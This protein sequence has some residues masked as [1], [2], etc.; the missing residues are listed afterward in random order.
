M[1]NNYISSI[2]NF[3]DYDTTYLN[4]TFFRWY[5]KLVPQL[6][7]RLLTLYSKEGDKILANFSGSGTVPLECLI[8]NR[9]CI[10][11]DSNPLS[12]LLSKV[13]TNPFNFDYNRFIDYLNKCNFVKNYIAIKDIE[14]K[15]FYKESLS[16]IYFL[17]QVIEEYNCSSSEKEYLLLVLVSII[18][19]SSLV[20]SRCVNHIV[21]D[22]NKKKID[23]I[24]EYKLKLKETSVEMD[25]LLK[26]INHTNSIRIMRGDARNLDFITNNDIDLI[27]A[28]PPYLGNVD[29]TNINQ[30]ENFILDYDNSKI[31]EQDISTN[32]LR[33]YLKNMYKV[34]DE[35]NRI[36]K[37]GSRACVII[38][39]NRQEGEIIPTF[40][41]FIQYALSI[42]F[43]LEDIFIW[44]LNKKAG[45]S[46]KRHGNY[47]DHNYILVFKKQE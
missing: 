6:V 24:G 31:R 34:F 3:R 10:A 35:M 19:K 12:I 21:L 36:L 23:V 33:K 29:Y 18:K 17:K 45:M 47:I 5:G 27:I 2:W 7:E 13:K 32:S 11:I 43:K 42:E 8:N 38:G 20:D 1:S 22:R 15:W 26:E 14:K 25:N 28:H 41:Y 9:D 30:L 44:V 39:D 4:H 16:D 37:P 40:S 46:V